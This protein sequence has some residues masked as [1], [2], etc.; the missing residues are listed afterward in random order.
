MRAAQQAHAQ[1]Q[2]Q[3]SS[4]AGPNPPADAAVR[5][6]LTCAMAAWQ[7][8]FSHPNIQVVRNW[9][10]VEAAVAVMSAVQAA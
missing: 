6:E 7:R 3:L 9:K 10:E 8:R 4:C 1:Q 2:Q 5:C